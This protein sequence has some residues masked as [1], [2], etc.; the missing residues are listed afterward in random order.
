MDEATINLIATALAGNFGSGNASERFTLRYPGFGQDEAYAVA[1]RVLALRRE[2]G[3][4]P[5]GRKIG[6]TNRLMWPVLGATGPF[7]GVMYHTTVFDLEEIDWRFDL[8][9]FPEPRIEPEIV[10]RLAKVPVAGMSEAELLTCVDAV[11]HGFELV[12]SP[13]VGWKFVAADATAAYG[14]HMALLL[15]PWH[16]VSRDRA[17][18]ASVLRGLTV[19]LESN[20]GARRHGAGR[21]VLGGPLTALRFL[22]DEVAVF[23]DR[24]KLSVGDIVTTGTLTEAMPVQ[25][26]QT[27]TTEVAGGP[28]RGISVRF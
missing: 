22:V 2:R 28:L 27:W 11:A 16:S 24:L 13:F 15:G 1:D 6:A 12:H 7:W 9:R 25:R 18:W 10:L 19:R 3:E 5:V 17:L 4:R 14:L 21:D 8:G 26:G 20:D 23:P